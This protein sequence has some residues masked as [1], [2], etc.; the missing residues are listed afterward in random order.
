MVKQ[1][2]EEASDSKDLLQT[3][4]D[5]A[6]AS[7]MEHNVAKTF[8][9]DN[10]KNI[11]FAGRETTATAASWVLILLAA[12]HEW[13]DRVRSEIAHVCGKNHPIT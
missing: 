11:Y 12:N 6:K 2:Q 10:C 9:I 7:Q 8:I 4:L 13:Q 5:E 3:I 1:G